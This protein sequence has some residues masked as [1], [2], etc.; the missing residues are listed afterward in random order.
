MDAIG[1]VRWSSEQQSRGDS[2]KRQVELIAAACTRNSWTLVETLI[3]NGKS[4]YHGKNRQDGSKLNEIEKRA[5]AGELAG[6]VLIVEQMDRLSRQQPLESVNLLSTLTKS[7]LLIHESSTGVTYDAQTTQ[8]KWQDLLIAFIRAGI[9]FEESLKKSKRLKAAWRS[10]QADP[11][12]KPDSRL[13]PSW[14]EVRDGTY[15][16]VESKADVVRGIFQRVIDGHSLRSICVDLNDKG[17]QLR[18]GG[19][20]P[21]NLSKLIRSRNV[22]GEYQPGTY[23]A[24]G[25]RLAYGDWIKVYPAIITHET[26]ARALSGLQGRQSAGGPRKQ[27]VNLLS[28]IARCGHETDEYCRNK[29]VLLHHR[30]KRLLQCGSYHRGGTCK[31]ATRYSY[32]VLVSGILDNV[33]EIALPA[34]EKPNADLLA[35]NAARDSLAQKRARLD[36]LADRMLENDDAVVERAYE[37]FKQ[38]VDE[39]A[40]D[41]K[42][43]EGALAIQQAKAPYTELAQYVASVRAQLD[44]RDVALKVH[45]ALKQM[46]AGVYLLPKTKG[47]I[48]DL[49]G[50]AR[51]LELDAEGK[52][53]DTYSLTHDTEFMDELAQSSASK[54]LAV[55]QLLER[56][57]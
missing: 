53:I 42:R 56:A 27:H 15:Q 20:T 57:A 16:I 37:R 6:K 38:Q 35:L 32:D 18:K 48:I 36:Q 7:G 46:V 44:D 24:H 12:T 51:F 49:A 45:A 14:I 52:L 2:E 4:A 40:V 25:H 50:G 10:R 17:I 29:A 5:A 13:C 31:C 11:H 1:Y 43:L 19:L 47:A 41:V 34:P 9:A 23:E 54:A 33:L 39:E 21:P 22:L 30:G 3:E 8:E 26:W 28:G 55:R